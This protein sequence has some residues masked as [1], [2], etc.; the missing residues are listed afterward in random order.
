MEKC[1]GELFCKSRDL[2]LFYSYRIEFL[3]YSYSYSILLLQARKSFQSFLTS[4]FLW[5][6]NHFETLCCVLVFLKITFLY[7]ILNSPAFC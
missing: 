1:Y 6:D 5:Q 7:Q 3:F 4:V 2:T